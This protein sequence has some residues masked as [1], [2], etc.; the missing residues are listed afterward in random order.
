MIFQNK[1]IWEPTTIGEIAFEYSNRCDVPSKSGYDKFVGSENIG[2]FD[3]TTKDWQSTKDVISAMKI[4]EQGD[5]LLV[6]RSLYASDFRERAPRATFDGIC[7]GDILTIKENNKKVANG[8]LFCV[9][10]S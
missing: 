5:Y 6:R 10:T 9:F 4:F 7:S 3:F 1:N 2:R 8:F